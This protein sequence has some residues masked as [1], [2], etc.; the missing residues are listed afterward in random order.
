[1]A[2]LHAH[3]DHKNCIESA[4][5]H[6]ATA[7]VRRFAEALI[8]GRGERHGHLNLVA[9]EVG[10]RHARGHKPPDH[11]APSPRAHFKPAR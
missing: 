8:A 7:E 11:G 4:T 1:M 3:L 5:L 9:A 10:Q 2:A 6:G